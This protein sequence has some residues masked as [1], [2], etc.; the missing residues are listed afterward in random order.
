MTMQGKDKLA[1]IQIIE[2][3]FEKDHPSLIVDP[4]RLCVENGN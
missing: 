1:I 3:C 2:D 4:E